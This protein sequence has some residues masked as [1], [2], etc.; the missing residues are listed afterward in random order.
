MVKAS[1]SATIFLLAVVVCL[2]AAPSAAAD[3]EVTLSSD[4][5]PALSGE[6][7]YG[8]ENSTGVVFFS[9]TGFP[10][11]ST[12]TINVSSALEVGDDLTVNGLHSGQSL[13]DIVISA[14]GCDCLRLSGQNSAI[15]GLT[16]IGGN[17]GI[18]ITGS[19]N[20][21]GSASGPNQ[22]LGNHSSGV[23]VSGGTSNLIE[24]NY[25]G[26]D[27][28]GAPS[29]NDGE[30]IRIVGGASG[31]GV[32]DNHVAANG[33]YGIS[34]NPA[35]DGASEITLTG[36]YV[37]TNLTGTAAAGNALG[38]IRVNGAVNVVVGGSRALGEGNL[39]SGHSGGAGIEFNACTQSGNACYGNLL[40]TDFLGQNSLANREGLVLTDSA[41]IS[42]GT[43]SDY[44][45][46]ISGNTV[47]GL[48]LTQSATG[49]VLTREN[50]IQ[51]NYV[52]VAS[53]GSSALP[54]G[55]GQAG[56]GGIIVE[57]NAG[58]NLIGGEAEG[59]GNVISANRGAGIILAASG[60]N[61]ISGNLVGSNASGLD[62]GNESCGLVLEGGSSSN[63]VQANIVAF[64]L[65]SDGIRA[66]EASTAY[67]LFRE[68]SIHSNQDLGIRLVDGA[69]QGLAAP[70]IEAVSW[71]SSTA[72]RVSGFRTSGCGVEVYRA[73]VAGSGPGQGQEYLGTSPPAAFTA[74]TI[75]EVSGLVEGEWLTAVQFSLQSSTSEFSANCRFAAE[76]PTA[77]PSVMPSPSCT[78]SRIPTVSPTPTASAPPSPT[79]RPP[80]LLHSF[81][82]DTD[83]GWTTESDWAFGV[84]A[85]WG[86]G[87]DPLNDGYPDPTSG[88]TGDNVYGYNLEGN[89]PNNMPAYYLT[90]TALDCSAATGITLYY[91]RWLNV[92]CIQH[93]KARLHYST[94]GVNW[95]KLSEN[96]NCPI[97]TTDSSWSRQTHSAPLAAYQ[98]EV[99]LRWEM[100]PSDELRGFS[101]WNID[102]IEIWGVP[103][104]TRTPTPTPSPSPTPTA[105]PSSSPSPTISPVPT[106]TPPPTASP[107]SSPLPTRTPASPVRAYF[108]PLDF[109]PSWNAGS[110]WEFGRPRGEGNDSG[111][112]N[113]DPTSGAT[114]I[115]VFGYNLAGDYSPGMAV[116]HL[117]TQALDCSFL[118]AISLRFQR[119]L[120]VERAQYD[121][122]KVEF[123]TDGINW[124]V[125]WENP[126]SFDIDTSDSSWRTVALNLPSSADGAAGLRLRWAMGPTDS[127]N[128]YSGWNIDDIEI[129]GIPTGPLP[130]PSPTGQPA[131]PTPAQTVVPSPS[132][133]PSPVP[134]PE[135]TPLLGV[136]LNPV[137]G[138]DYAG[139]GTVR[140]AVF[141]S[142]EGLWVVRGVSRFYFAA[143]ADQPVSGD[144]DGDGTDEAAIFRATTSLWKVRFL[145]RFYF[146]RAADR[147]VP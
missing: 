133:T 140:P 107:T 146:G 124:V 6:L 108:F 7:R 25:V 129:W 47:C 71:L 122:A 35:G 79:P 26:I 78:P 136:W 86:G 9:Q 12:T 145:S 19:Y 44:R 144:Y 66:A 95:I 115:N 84:P 49:S 28:T 80:E 27:A 58:D 50:L 36:N 128:N 34:I 97:N 74:W 2:Y 116:S 143:L 46:V 105:S 13:G 68:N 17:V 3:Y 138:G 101:G 137:A 120:N 4:S 57:E 93:D 127:F 119:W 88:H 85:G 104:A 83:P 54:N 92:E 65:H 29:G 118:E 15:Y 22:I 82:L 125:L 62:L 56:E 37:G 147:R 90:T 69:N 123:S 100:G 31:V 77:T 67:N 14:S 87:T 5:E 114:G 142:A 75:E 48:R 41:S 63:L 134:S 139:D 59:Q 18:E 21:V 51:G 103:Q 33:S 121:H 39:V 72:A 20:Q 11:G 43:S 38:G 135:P 106:A 110:G 111:W 109:N 141:R 81:P 16:L 23:R 73:D 32:V 53:D 94:D 91:W 132:P 99:Y 130:G 10:A 126:F 52:G 24:A 89:Y 60:G 113:P 131:S 61:F 76:T 96:L 1:A 45:N 42:V 30:G 70:E 40:G 98:P 55:S 112:F 102:D 117:S 64:N 8:L